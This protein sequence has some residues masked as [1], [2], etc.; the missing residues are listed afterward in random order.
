VPIQQKANPFQEIIECQPAC[1]YLQ[2]GFF[3]MILMSGQLGRKEK[4]DV[5]F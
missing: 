4:I 5:K 2:V 3:A 1:F